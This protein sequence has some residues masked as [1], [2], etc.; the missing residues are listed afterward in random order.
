LGTFPGRK[1]K[2]RM[3][4]FSHMLFFGAFGVQETGGSVRGGVTGVESSTLQR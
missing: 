2:K 1:A 4:C 3:L